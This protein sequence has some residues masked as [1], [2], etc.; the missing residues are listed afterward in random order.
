MTTLLV[1]ANNLSVRVW[2]GSPELNTSKGTPVHV[3]FGVLRAIKAA[4]TTFK[5][6][7]VLAV[8]DGSPTVRSQM[9]SGYK[10][11]RKQ[12]RVDHTPEEQESYAQFKQQM[13]VLKD[14]LPHFGVNQAFE[15]NSEADDIIAVWCKDCLKP[16]VVILSEDKDFIQLVSSTVTLHRPMAKMTYTP[17]NFQELTG[18]SNTEQYLNYRVLNGDDSDEIPCVPGFGGK[19]GKRAKELISKYFTVNNIFKH[20][21]EL[22]K[23]KVMSV[24]FN[25]KQEIIR[26][27]MLMNLDHSETY[28]GVPLKRIITPGEFD[29]AEVKRHLMKL[30]F[31]SLLSSFKEFASCFRNLTGFDVL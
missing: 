2:K 7:N 18:F 22:N 5:V 13:A 9:F 27:F 21:A 25:S 28:L 24:L 16:T 26:N 1:D 8:W 11:K 31:F 10:A 12:A 15:S 4:I 6:S 30:E 14:I 23:G 17:D 19:E 20:E 3:V 29:E